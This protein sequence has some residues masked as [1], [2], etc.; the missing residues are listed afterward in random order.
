[1]AGD[2]LGIPDPMQVRAVA[3]EPDLKGVPA[4]VVILADMEWLVQVPDQVDNVS[5][6]HPAGGQRAGPIP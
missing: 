5:Q 6:R 3:E 1:M 2:D 4:L